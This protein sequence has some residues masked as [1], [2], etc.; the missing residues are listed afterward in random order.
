MSDVGDVTAAC[1]D[2]EISR[3]TD[4]VPWPYTEDD[5]RTWISTHG[6]LWERGEVAPFAIVEAVDGR[7][8]GA[9]SLMFPEDPLPGAGYQVAEWGRNRGVATGALLPVTQ[10]GFG[11]LG[12]KPVSPAT[13]LGNVASERV[14]QKAGCVFD[15][16]FS[17][18]TA[19]SAALG[20]GR[21]RGGRRVGRR[22]SRRQG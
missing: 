10:W 14:A 22:T 8:L 5:A 6:G 1:Q 20:L 13:M 7:F 18:R 12:L 9:V 3:W 16:E 2:R 4:A 19:G 15:G 21:P 11:T 17:P